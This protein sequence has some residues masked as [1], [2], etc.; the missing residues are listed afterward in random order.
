[1]EARC[2]LPDAAVRAP[3]RWLAALAV[4]CAIALGLIVAHK[5]SQ[6]AVRVHGSDSS[7]PLGNKAG[8]EGETLPP[9]IL[10]RTRCFED[11]EA[12]T[13]RI[14]ACGYPGASNVG[15][16]KSATL[17]ETTSCPTLTGT[18]HY[19]DKKLVGKDC[20]I[21]VAYNA[22]GVVIRNDEIVM[23]ESCPPPRLSLNYGCTG[24]AIEFERKGSGSGEAVNEAAKN[25]RIEH[26]FVHGL[27]RHGVNT[28]QT[29][30]DARWN[31]PYVA[32]Y[33]KTE[34]CS[35]FKLNAGG[36][37]NHDY[38]PSNY[39]IGGEHYECV[40]DEGSELNAT[41]LR[42]P[43]VI[44]NSTILQPPVKESIESSGLTAAI[45][46]Q[47]LYGPIQET[48]LEKD[49]LAGGNFTLYFGEEAG[50]AYKLA[51]HDTVR[52]NRFARCVTK[53]RCPDSEGYFEEVGAYH[54]AA[55]YNE[56]K[57]VWEHNFIDNGLEECKLGVGVCY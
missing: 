48:I 49:L 38:C 16:E 26:V 54:I 1:V 36:E 7:R 5:S 22:T 29:C 57:M 55:F 34:H 51:G 45:F 23:K 12:G 13:A 43:L 44:R 47:S 50:Q 28:V 42:T 56:S 46:Q 17:T 21:T 52:Y 20:G 14:E 53:G 2:S 25:T 40:T 9:P 10:T 24:N 11:P 27:E 33:V 39:E 4:A 6:P 32:E 35:G 31:S 41:T 3:V 30:V 15:V 8:V 37:M 19:E 18:E